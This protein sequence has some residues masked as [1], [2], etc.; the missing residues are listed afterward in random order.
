MRSKHITTI[1]N[2]A[3][4]PY[5]QTPATYK[6]NPKKY[7]FRVID[8]RYGLGNRIQGAGIRTCLRTDLVKE[9]YSYE[10]IDKIYSYEKIE[11]Y[12]KDLS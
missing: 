12:G 2:G 6:P 4:G 7:V 1:P 5:S 8:I 3:M 9:N 10:E 11:K